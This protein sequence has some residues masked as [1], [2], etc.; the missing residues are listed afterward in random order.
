VKFYKKERKKERKKKEKKKKKKKKKSTYFAGGRIDGSIDTL[1][2]GEA[3]Q[4]NSKGEDNFMLRY[5][6]NCLLPCLYLYYS[7]ILTGKIYIQRSD[8]FPC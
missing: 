5:V 7:F 2:I 8:S 6:P 1:V 4:S 3:T